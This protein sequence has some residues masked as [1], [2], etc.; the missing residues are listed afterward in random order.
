MSLSDVVNI[1]ITR[2][3][4]VPTR[5]GFGTLA[6]FCYHTLNNNL[7]NEVSEADEVLD[8]GATTAHRAY[9]AALRHFSQEPRPEKML[10]V[11]RG[12]QTQILELTPVTL[13]VGYTYAFTI[14]DPTGAE[15]DIEHTVVTGTV[16]AIVDALVTAITTA[17]PASVTPTADAGTATKLIL[18]GAA[19]VLFGLKNLPQPSEM[20]VYDATVAG[21]AAADVSAFLASVYAGQAYAFGFDRTSEAEAVAIAAVVEAVRKMAFV[22]TSDTEV[23]EG[24]DSDDIASQ[25][26]ALNYARTVPFYLA[27]ETNG[28]QSVGWTGRNLPYDPG[29]ETWAHKTVKGI[30]ADE[31]LSGQETA[32]ETKR[33]NFYTNIGGL[34]VVRWGQVPDGDYVDIIRGVDWLHAR[35]G[36]AIWGGF[37][38]LPK[39]PF[40]DKGIAIV[41][42]LMRG[43]L[44][45]AVTVGLLESYEI[46]VPKAADV[47]TADKAARTLTGV[48]F[49]GVLQGA[50][51]KV[52]ITGNVAL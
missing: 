41:E 27:N 21:T 26:K 14:V 2:S 31:L 4:K 42:N 3:T 47:D 43:V 18:T 32:C 34:D 44:D 6:F 38:N 22:D 50:I 25:L 19:G 29:S 28:F 40:T 1:S 33:A 39:V 45:R 46:I 11:K 37:Y 10:I 7:V 12:T 8:L 30:V 15:F 17:A 16:D 35:L 36:E 9:K 49:T 13:T 24:G 20:K 23:V 5:A 52:T 48:S 51:H